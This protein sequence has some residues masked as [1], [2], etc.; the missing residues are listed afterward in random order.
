MIGQDGEVGQ[1]CHNKT[2]FP[3]TEVTI[4]KFPTSTEGILRK[5]LSPLKTGVVVVPPDDW[6]AVLIYASPVVIM[7]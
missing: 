4:K 5:I 2:I 1:S 3:N 6:P 7:V